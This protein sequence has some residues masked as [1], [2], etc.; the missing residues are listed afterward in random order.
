MKTYSGVDSDG[1]GVHNICDNCWAAFNPSQADFDAD[2][3]GNSCDNCLFLENPNQEDLDSDLRGDVCDN[4]PVESNTLQDDTDGDTVGDVCD[5]CAL[6]PNVDQS[7]FDADFDGDRCDLDDGLIYVNVLGP[8][9]MQYQQEVGYVA[10][11]VYRGE[12]AVLAGMGIYSQN[13]SEVA[14]ADQ[15][16]GEISGSVFDPFLPQV[17]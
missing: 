9:S 1:D 10:F 16:C 4:C 12:M 3:V 5:N 8:A 13:P 7:D 14:G 15:F 17:A 2:S 11:N 6:E